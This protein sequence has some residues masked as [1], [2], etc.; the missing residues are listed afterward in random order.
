MFTTESKAAA[1]AIYNNLIDDDGWTYHVMP[2]GKYFFVE[3][4]DE[5]GNVLG[6]L[7]V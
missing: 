5:D 6:P 3:V 1:A 4:R 2:K 7:P